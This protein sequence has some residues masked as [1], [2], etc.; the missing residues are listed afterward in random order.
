MRSFHAGTA[1]AVCLLSA[2]L[3]AQSGNALLAKILQEAEAFEKLAGNPD[4]RTSAM[5][6]MQLKTLTIGVGQA[7]SKAGELD[8]PTYGT[9][10]TGASGVGFYMQRPDSTGR[11][12]WLVLCADVARYLAASVYSKQG[13]SFYCPSAESVFSGIAAG[14]SSRPKPTWP[15]ITEQGR[16]SAA[17][18]ETYA[19][20]LMPGLLGAIYHE[21]FDHVADDVNTRNYLGALALEY[22]KRCG[23][24]FGALSTRLKVLK[25]WAYY[26]T[27]AQG[28]V[29]SNAFANHP[30]GFVNAWLLRD[31][32]TTAHGDEM[33]IAD[34][35]SVIGTSCRGGQPNDDELMKT[36]RGKA[37]LKIYQ[38]IVK[39]A[40]QRIDLPPDV[41][42]NAFFRG[43]LAKRNPPLQVELSFNDA[44]ADTMRKVRKACENIMPGLIP[45]SIVGQR[46][47][48]YCRCHALMLGRTIPVQ[49]LQSLA[50][51]FS[52]DKLGSLEARYPAYARLAVACKQ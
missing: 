23:E 37:S 10:R 30:D 46:E 16:S 42:N 27:K 28:S 24:K 40:N 8:Y 19:P 47:E 49:D 18:P 52:N 5:I 7:Q 13:L 35:A 9:I 1:M 38:S 4:S 15:D 50:T 41:P 51:Q 6:R 45:N 2:V 29:F 26:E 3:S 31:R 32:V 12:S 21:D 14:V 43:G 44:A 17:L 33:A 36:T 22:Y 11:E 48:S 34:A 20:V 25:Y 39:L